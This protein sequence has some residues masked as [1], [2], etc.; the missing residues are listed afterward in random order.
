MTGHNTGAIVFDNVLFAMSGQAVVSNLSFQ[1]PCGTVAAIVGPNGAGKS[2]LLK[3]ASGYYRPV[4]GK[5]TVMGQEPYKLK[6]RELVR[7]VTYCGDEPEPAFDFT[8]WETVLM[9]RTSMIPSFAGPSRADIEAAQRAMKE[10]N[11]SDL[12]D[13]AV[14]SLS[15]GERQRVFLARA[16]C[17][18]SLVFLLD[19]PTAHLDMAHELSVMELLIGLTSDRGKTVLV[20]LHDLNLA[21]RYASSISFMKDGQLVASI[22]PGEI[23][24][25]II[26]QVYGVKA[27]VLTHPSLKCPMVVPLEPVDGISCRRQ[28]L[29]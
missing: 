8:V 12:A 18:D 25:D 23:R 13:R 24:P 15:S 4:Q 2:T 14:T 9:G 10:M 3:L 28:G 11:I 27:E 26:W 5:V 7:L 1:V 6:P 17:Q 19:E 21:L 29:Q 16:L 20:V 22:L